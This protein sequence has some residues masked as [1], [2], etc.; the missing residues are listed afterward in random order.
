ME[1]EVGVTRDRPANAAATAGP[2]K[3]SAVHGT[4]RS[5]ARLYE[6]V[7]DVEAADELWTQ[8]QRLA[9]RQRAVLVL[10][11]YEALSEQQTAD[12][13]GCSVATV[14]SLTAR[15]LTGM[16]AQQGGER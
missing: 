1:R 5:L 4:S 14:K 16:R 7:P 9:A 3:T 12:V 15:G 10:R 13:L 11:Y 8:L 2:A 6:P